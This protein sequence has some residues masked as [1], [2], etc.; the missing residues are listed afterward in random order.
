MPVSRGISQLC[1]TWYMQPTSLQDI[2]Y[3]DSASRGPLGNIRLLFRLR[4]MYFAFALLVTS[5]FLTRRRH[6]ASLGA[7]I[8]IVSLA[9]DPLFQQSVRYNSQPAVDPIRQAQ[10]AAAH[11]YDTNNTF[12]GEFGS[13]CKWNALG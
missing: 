3:Y 12:T 5:N 13:A 1:L 11:T 6:L 9:L 4:F 10:T 8:T 7:I 2:C